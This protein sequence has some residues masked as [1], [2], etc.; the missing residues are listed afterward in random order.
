[1]RQT[2]SARLDSFDQ[3]SFGGKQVKVEFQ[4]DT[5]RRKDSK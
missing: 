3:S 2:V 4:D 5:K 1:M